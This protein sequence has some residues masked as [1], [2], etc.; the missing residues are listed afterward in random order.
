MQAGVRRREYNT[1]VLNADF[2]PLSNWPPSIIT[3]REAIEGLC[4]DRYTVV[5]TW[6]AAFRSPSTTIQV[7]KVVALREFKRVRGTPKFCRRSILLRDHYRC[8]YCGE[9]FPISELTYDHYIPR[10]KGG[11]TTWDNIL[12]ACLKCNAIK[13]DKHLTPRSLPR[14]PTKLEL[15]QAGMQHLPADLKEDFGSYLYWNVELDA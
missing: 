10:S 8:Q 14:C 7:P 3:A 6:D 9:K 1:L 11:K 2:R 4:R 13:S 5:E 15:L 12:T